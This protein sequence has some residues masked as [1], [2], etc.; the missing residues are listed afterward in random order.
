MSSKTL[1]VVRFHNY[2]KLLKVAAPWIDVAIVFTHDGNFC[3][4]SNHQLH[5]QMERIKVFT[6]LFQE[7]VDNN[8][9]TELVY[10]L[11][12]G[13]ELVL[14]QLS[15]PDIEI[16]LTVALMTQEIG[17][18][19]TLSNDKNTIKLLNQT[20]LTEYS[21]IKKNLE[22]EQELNAIA[23]ELTH[24]YEELNLIYSSDAN[25]QNM[26]HG[27]E[28]LQQII[29]NASNY[30]DVDLV[31]I[32]LPEKNV[33]LHHSRHKNSS[34]RF[35]QILQSLRQEIFIQLQLHKSSIVINRL[36]DA[37]K[38]NIFIDL[39]YKAV[40]SP[41]L[42]AENTVIGL[43]AIINESNRMD[44]SNSDRNLLEV[45]A[46]KA[47]SIVVHNIDPLTGLENSH[48]F[49][50][51]VNDALKQSWKN[52]NQHAIANIDIDRMSIINSISGL[53]AGDSLIK[54]IANTLS[55]MAKSYDTVCRLGSD[56][57]AILM[58]D[59]DLEEALIL[60]Q[61]MAKEVSSIKMEWEHHTYEVSISIGIAPITTDIQTVSNVL[62]NAESARIA[63]K[64][65]GCNQTQVFKLD[66]RDLLHRKQLISWVTK[67]QSALR[68]NRFELHAQLIQPILPSQNLA[69][70]EILIRM[71]NKEGNLIFP[72]NFLPAA[73]NF[74]MMPK[75]DRWVIK[76][77]FKL[78][79]QQFQKTGR[80]ICDV[81]INLSGQSITSSGLHDYIESM[82]GKYSIDPGTICFEITETS[83]MA[84][85]AEAQ[86]FIANIRKLGCSFSLDDFGTGLSSF[87]YLQNLSVD[88]LKIDGSFVK[89]IVDNKVSSS[90]V[91]AINQVGHAM[92]LKTIAEYVENEAILEKLKI[93]GVDYAQG[94]AIHK[95]Q[96]FR[97]QL[98]NL[99]DKLSQT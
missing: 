23:N 24:R 58:K 4:Q 32:T 38:N 43:I 90:M 11:G 8:E 76:N 20:L 80:N 59:C 6:K 35:Q 65:R 49:E 62:G 33:T 17:K 82:M 30:M 16:S 71:L 81:S 85:L 63:A 28:L 19:Q 34:H 48:S 18:K 29:V 42:N 94:Y 12:D 39:P 78:L 13:K 22:K 15:D 67:T 45:L 93:L 91:S 5:P 46:N 84:N 9:L 87:A 88:Y 50:M 96:P 64:E 44:F 21:L 89:H 61:K 53:Q 47:S 74:F 72:N 37:L 99:N 55:H 26:S 40:I 98:A 97:E 66:D 14:M 10:K 27:R 60:M 41:I 54:K 92:N 52:G 25:I 79:H 57:F 75:L 83:A 1:N 68:E 56:K 95:P 73:E 51:I 2:W 7:Q 3:W 69:H 36:D 86:Q 70:F 31:T 77:T